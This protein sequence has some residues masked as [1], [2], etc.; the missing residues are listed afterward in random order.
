MTPISRLKMQEH[1]SEEMK[2]YSF[3]VLTPCFLEDKVSLITVI[4]FLQTWFNLQIFSVSQTKEEYF[5]NVARIALAIRLSDLRDVKD[6]F[7][8]MKIA[9]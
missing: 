3:E 9:L 1:L 6:I 2:N 7:H 5:E 8:K 4:Q